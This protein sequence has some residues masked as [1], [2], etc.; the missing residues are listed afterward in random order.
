MLVAIPL[1]ERL[2]AAAGVSSDSDM[3]LR[4]AELLSGRDRRD[5]GT[6]APVLPASCPNSCKRR[7][8]TC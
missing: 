3:G 8:D 2:T 7:A 6:G 5:Q 1:F 4:L